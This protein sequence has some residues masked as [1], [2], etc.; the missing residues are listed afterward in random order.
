VP[1]TRKRPPPPEPDGPPLGNVLDFMRLLWA[2]NHELDSLS[3]RMASIFGVTGP[4]RLVVRIVGRRPQITAGE[5]AEVLRVHPSTLTGVLHRLVARG[6]IARHRDPDDARRA[7]FSLTA[8]GRAIDALRRGTVEAAISR[9][10]RRVAPGKLGAATRILEE[11]AASLRS[12][13][14]R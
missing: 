6:L 8:Q 1:S 7:Q 9:G 5:L 11:L 14:R 3:K 2:L 4:Q 10:L 13:A 12:E